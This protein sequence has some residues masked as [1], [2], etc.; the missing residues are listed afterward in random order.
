MQSLCQ[1]RCC[2]SLSITSHVSMV[3]ELLICGGL[4]TTAATTLKAGRR[5]VLASTAEITA[6]Q[7]DDPAVLSQ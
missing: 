2:S 5:W 6:L 1:R 7:L 4:I 3:E